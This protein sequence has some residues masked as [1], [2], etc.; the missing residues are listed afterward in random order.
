MFNN[1]RL[2]K[3]IYWFLAALIAAQGAA[4]QQTSEFQPRLLNLEGKEVDPFGPAESKV[5]VFFFLRS[6][7]PISNRYAPEVRRLHQKFASRDVA[8]WLVYVDAGE[9]IDAIRSHMEDYD[10]SLGVLRDPQ[11]TLVRFCGVTVTPEAAIFTRGRKLVYRGRIDDRYLDFGRARRVPTT[12]DVEQVLQAIVDG[13]V[14]KA[15]TTEAIGCFI[16]DLR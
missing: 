1:N 6:D 13:R 4:A 10:Y 5:T 7:C 11:H 3:C 2:F 14:I 12:R 16:S 15:K 8:F 9:S